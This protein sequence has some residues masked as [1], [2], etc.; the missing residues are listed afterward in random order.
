MT[1]INQSI[2][3]T[4]MTHGST[5]GSQALIHDPRDTYEFDDPFIHYHSAVVLSSELRSCISELVNSSV[6]GT[7]HVRLIAR[8]HA[9]GF[10]G[11][12]SCG[13]VT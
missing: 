5:D 13:C 10:A 9:A 2:N 3:Q 6:L 12:V 7:L 1:H 4:H 11:P 8:S